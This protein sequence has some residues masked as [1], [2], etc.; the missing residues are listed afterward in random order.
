MKQIK[1]IHHISLSAP[2]C[3]GFEKAMHFYHDLLG[4]PLI[5]SWGVRPAG[6][7]MLDAGGCILEIMANGSEDDTKGQWG[8][9]AFAVED[10][11]AL[12]ELLRKEGY[13]IKM[14]PCDK[15]LDGY[16]VHIAFCYGPC[17]EEI[18]LFQEH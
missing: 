5:R 11:D 15:D 12:A 18:E 9:I 3:A 6:G 4:I 16:P 14:E 2:G 8:H 13:G 7:A 10:V 17:G 1:M